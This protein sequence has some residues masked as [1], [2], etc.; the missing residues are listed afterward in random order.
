[1]IL[2][3]CL[4]LGGAYL[5]AS[6]SGSYARVAYTGGGVRGARQAFET[7]VVATLRSSRAAPCICAYCF[8]REQRLKR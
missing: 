2:G 7:A 5:H 8:R 4:Q 1:M 6:F 3:V